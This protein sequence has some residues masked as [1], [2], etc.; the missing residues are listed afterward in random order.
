MRNL[1][2]ECLFKMWMEMAMPELVAANDNC[3]VV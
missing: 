2:D 3:G 1:C